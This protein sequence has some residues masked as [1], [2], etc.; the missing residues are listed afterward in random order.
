M[1][2]RPALYPRL[3]VR[4]NLRLFAALE[5]AERPGELA[6]ELIARADLGEFADRAGRRSCPPAPSSG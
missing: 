3:T 1:P 4:E 2:Q 5:G 6:A